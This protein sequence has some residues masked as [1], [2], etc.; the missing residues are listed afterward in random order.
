MLM[1][2]RESWKK[3][4]PW[5]LGTLIAMLLALAWYV[6]Y[7]LWWGPWDWPS[8]ASPPGFAFGLLGGGIILFEML[9]WPR[10]S[11]LRGWRLGP[12]KTWML[13]HLWLGLLSLPLLLLHG[14]FHFDPQTSTLAAVLMWILVAVVASGVFGLVTQNVIPRLM[15]EQIPAE[16]I[17]SQIGHVLTQ[18]RADAER[19]VT[20]TCGRSPVSPKAEA[21]ATPPVA[22]SDLTSLVSVE[23]MRHVGRVQGRV[24]Q[25]GLEAGW[26]AG[27]EPLIAFYQ[28]QIEPYLQAKSG[29]RLALGS[30][31]RADALFAALKKRLSPDASP[32]I[33]RLADL[34]EQ[35]RQFDLQSRLHFWLH[36]WL[37]AHVALS[38]GL[39]L[40]MVIHAVLALKYL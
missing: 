8:G 33:D 9:L 25:V 12:T 31:K 3:H 34:C 35:R 5:C 13:A 11:L 39:T 37:V 7:G 36:S 24:V 15:L 21:A 27:S 10:K 2:D 40:L 4:R 14:S 28:D 19:L 1:F 17:Y 30:S 6:A 29:A 18:Y 23:T 32:V 22:A 16:T 20:L 26:V 38:V